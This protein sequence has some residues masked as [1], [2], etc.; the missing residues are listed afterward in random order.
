MSL[1]TDATGQVRDRLGHKRQTNTTTHR[2]ECHW[3]CYE[4][5]LTDWSFMRALLSLLTN[6][7]VE[8]NVSEQFLSENKAA[9]C[10]FIRQKKICC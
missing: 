3:D 9:I 2:A 7:T 5:K 1:A 8:K 10:N 6:V 4:Y